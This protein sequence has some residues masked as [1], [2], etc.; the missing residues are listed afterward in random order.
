[1]IRYGILVH[2]HCQPM[3]RTLDLLA[4]GDTTTDTFM[5]IDEGR[6]DCPINRT[7][8]E[9]VLPYGKKVPV[10]TMVTVHGAGNAANCA[11]GVA[12]LGFNS[13]LFSV[14]GNDLRGKEA[15]TALKEIGVD[16][17]LVVFDKTHSTNASTV[18]GIEGDRTILVHHAPHTY[19]KKNLPR[20]HWIYFSS[21]GSDHSQM[22]TI[23]TQTVKKTGTKVAF[24]PGTMQ[25]RL[26]RETLAPLLAV[27]E[28]LFVN[29]E[30]G[31]VLA[32]KRD[33]LLELLQALRQLGPKIVVV[34]DGHKGSYT[35]D[36][37][38]AYVIGISDAKVVERTGAG[39]AYAS[40]F[41]SAL[42]Y[43]YDI[44]EAMRWGSF[45]SAGVVQYIGSR[46]GL[47]NKKKICA[48][49]DAQSDFYPTSLVRA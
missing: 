36:G 7:D 25:L 19:P 41:L 47:L 3:F 18:I 44:K 49:S 35:Y 39:D 45:N 37:K 23:I 38:N 31:E 5:M 6:I 42:M 20:S 10:K 27:V 34:T 28:V 40:G 43:N 21:V 46:A 48:M 12:S 8:C 32:G 17:S 29:K 30:E 4:I 26:G 9:L 22:H 14:V 33:S 24:N 11:A 16:T 2:Y 1:M 15:V 13:A